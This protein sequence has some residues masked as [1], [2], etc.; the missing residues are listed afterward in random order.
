[1]II[2]E[3]YKALLSSF[4]GKDHSFYILIDN[5]NYN[6]I[7]DQILNEITDYHQSP[8]VIRPF[9]M[10]CVKYEEKYTRAWIKSIDSLFRLTSKII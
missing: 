10:V 3:Q 9:M 6:E 2:G 1:M 5:H 4:S 8:L 7:I